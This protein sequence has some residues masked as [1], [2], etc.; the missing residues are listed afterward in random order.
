VRREVSKHDGDGVP[1]EG[2]ILQTTGLEFDH[3]GC[4]G[5]RNQE[6]KSTA[7]HNPIMI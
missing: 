1:G 6:E 5:S 2:L 3:L 4:R 7:S